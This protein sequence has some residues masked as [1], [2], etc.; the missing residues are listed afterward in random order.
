[1]PFLT[2]ENPNPIQTKCIYAIRDVCNTMSEHYYN[3]SILLNVFK[4]FFNYLQ[5][6]LVK[7]ID[8]LSTIKDQDLL[9][10]IKISF[11]DECLLLLKSF[12]CF[13]ICSIRCFI[14]DLYYLL[15]H[16]H[17]SNKCHEF[18]P[19]C[20]FY[21]PQESLKHIELRL[22]MYNKDYITFIQIHFL[23]LKTIIDTACKNHE[24]ECKHNCKC[25]C[26]NLKNLFD[27]HPTD[28]NM[29]L[30]LSQSKSVWSMF[31]LTQQGVNELFAYEKLTILE[32]NVIGYYNKS[33]KYET[34]FYKQKEEEFEHRSFTISKTWCRNAYN[35]YKATCKFLEDPI[36]SE[37]TDN[38][39]IPQNKHIKQLIYQCT[40]KRDRYT[41][42]CQYERDKGH[43]TQVQTLKSKIKECA[44]IINQQQEII[45]SRFKFNMIV[46]A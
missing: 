6:I 28:Y 25:N 41:K 34:P 26:N 7:K 13:Q 46:S 5:S 16:E 12:D 4:V 29:P 15:K 20:T 18:D 24:K 21:F 30:D 39:S 3:E 19:L 23:L 17:A 31:H 42:E 44:E 11:I 27:D 10:T 36:Q 22:F 40:S 35:D 8:L 32:D 1:M 9:H 2:V 37:C 14:D 38:Y 43:N 45:L 33:F